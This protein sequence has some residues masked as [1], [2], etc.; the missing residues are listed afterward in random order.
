LG[1]FQLEKGSEKNVKGCGRAEEETGFLRI[2]TKAEE[3]S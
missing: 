1:K 3:L 2:F